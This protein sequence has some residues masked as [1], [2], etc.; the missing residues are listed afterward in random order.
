MLTRLREIAAGSERTSE[1]ASFDVSI[2]CVQL[3]LTDGT[4]ANG[5]CIRRGSVI[6]GSGH[7]THAEITIF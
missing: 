2:A 5:A 7:K 6:T 3:G 1:R 4:M